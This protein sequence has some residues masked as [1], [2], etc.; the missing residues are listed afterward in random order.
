MERP[1]GFPPH[2]HS[3][4]NRYGCFSA[5]RKNPIDSSVF[6][7]GMMLRKDLWVRRR[8]MSASARLLLWS[9]ILDRISSFSSTGRAS[10]G[11]RL[12]LGGFC[13]AASGAMMRCKTRR[14]FLLETNVLADLGDL[15]GFEGGDL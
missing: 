5:A 8:I 14:I 3:N 4:G 9:G 11:G 15:Y 1:L 10:K 13:G 12:V 6:G 7:L 2:P